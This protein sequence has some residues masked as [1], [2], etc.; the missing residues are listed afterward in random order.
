MGFNEQELTKTVPGILEEVVILEIHRNFQNEFKTE[1]C[2]RMKCAFKSLT[3]KTISRRFSSIA[4]FAQLQ[5]FQIDILQDLHF[6]RLTDKRC[7]NFRQTKNQKYDFQK[8]YTY[9]TTVKIRFS[10]VR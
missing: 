10:E 9:V 5:K 6:Y 1:K 3:F 8:C 2:S 7:Y 4:R